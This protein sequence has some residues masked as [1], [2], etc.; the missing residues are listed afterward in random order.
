MLELNPKTWDA[1]AI[2]MPELLRELKASDLVAR[3]DLAKHLKEDAKGIYVFYDGGKP[4]YVGRS[5][6]EDGSPNRMRTRIQEHGW[7]SSTGSAAFAFLLAKEEAE[8]Q[9][10]DCKSQTRSDLQKAPEFKP[11]FD[12]AKAQVRQM[13]TRVVQVTDAIDQTVFEVYAALMLGTTVQQGGYNDF[14]N[15]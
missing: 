14:E 3:D 11:F 4:L 9:E 10:I 15:H 8:K 1:I 6:K 5:G 12:E 13:Q 2:R 7:E